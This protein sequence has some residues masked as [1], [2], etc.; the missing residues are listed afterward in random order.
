MNNSWTQIKQEIHNRP[1]LMALPVMALLWNCLCYQGGRLLGRTTYHFDMTLPID[2]MIPV[3][4][5]TMVIYWGCLAVWGVVYIWMAYRSKES[6]MRY[7]IAHLISHFICFLF[8]VFLPTTNARPEIVGDDF[9]SLILIGQYTVDS[10]DNLFPSLHCVVS[11]LCWVGVRGEKDCPA[12]AKWAVFI[13]AV[14]VMLAI[15]LTKQH[16][17]VDI[18]AAIVVAEVSYYIASVL[19][20]KLLN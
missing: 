18:P 7:Y 16:V 20:K 2:D 19:T 1:K 9:W 4:P 10:A 6:T 3:V 12:W 15:L 11:Y 5:W 17:V 13:A 14:A 8:F